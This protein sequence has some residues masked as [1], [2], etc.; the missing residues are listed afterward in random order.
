MLLHGIFPAIT[1]PFYPD[2]RVYAR[3]LEHNVDLYAK[4]PVAG[5]VVLGST[6]E[7]V[8]LS[9]EERRETLKTARNA[10]TP[11]KVLVAGTGAESARETLALTEYAA[12]LGYDAAL[13]RTPY[14]YRQQMQPGNILAFYRFV[15]DRSPLPVVLYS[16]PAFT[17]Y[18]LP[19][20]VVT[21]L[22]AHPNIIAIKESS[23]DLEKVESLVERTRHIKRQVTVTEQ[24][25]AVTGRMLLPPAPEGS[26]GFVS[27]QALGGTAVAAAPPKLKARQKEVGFQILVGA[28]QALQ[29]ALD[30]GAVGAVLAF[31]AAAPTSCFE[32]YA[33]WKDGDHQLAGEKQQRIATAAAKLVGQYGVPGLKHAM[34]WNGYYG[35]PPRLPLLP[36]TAEIKA[37]IQHLMADIRN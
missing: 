14:F 34:D 35:G 18:D 24:Q 29:A 7:A 5:I 22:A 1:T 17:G 4:A 10:A 33:A 21:E 23:G 28:A 2:G 12:A 25:Q 27:A 8:M 26:A 9:D 31:A 20:E 36:P 19:L 6:G 37:G 11:D 13:V 3:K 16:V 15:A 30:L 32:I